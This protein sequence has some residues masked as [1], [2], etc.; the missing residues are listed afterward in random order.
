MIFRAD[1][2]A[3]GYEPRAWF[4]GATAKAFGSGTNDRFLFTATDQAL[5]STTRMTVSGMGASQSALLLLAAPSPDLTF[6]RS[7]EPHW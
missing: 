2:G 1:D 7:D 6:R 4:T 5:G 3:Q